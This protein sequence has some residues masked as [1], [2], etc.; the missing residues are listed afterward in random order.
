MK[1]VIISDTHCK[2][3]SI[4]IPTCD[5]LISCGDYSFRGEWN[6]VKDFHSWLDKVPA[7]NVISVQ[8]NHELWVEKNFQEAKLI[9]QEVCPRGHFIEE[10]LIEIDGIKI[11]GSAWSP[12]FNN[13]AY[14][15]YRGED[16]K[17]HWD[18]I[19]DDIDI[20]ITHGPPA[21]ILDMVRYANGTPKEHAGCTNLR[22]KVFT[23]NK[24]KLHC[25]GHMHS[26]SGELDING[27]KFIN[28][29]ICDE[30]YSATNPIREFEL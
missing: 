7:T 6:I 5:L 9:A 26:E 1:I 29:S 23:L 27:V 21:G 17:K 15:A 11:W 20:L 24:L 2:W 19:P 13:W 14:N 12:W 16:I 10:G 8:G 18:K 25:F 22:D 28:A 3:S 4:A 30:L